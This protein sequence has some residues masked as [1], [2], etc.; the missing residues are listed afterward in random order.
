ML[1]LDLPQRPPGAELRTTAEACALDSQDGVSLCLA[2]GDSPV[3]QPTGLYVRLGKRCFDVAF[4]TTFVVCAATWLFPLIA[5]A[6]RLDSKGP[7]FFRQNRVGFGGRVFSCLKFRTMNHDPEAAFTQAAPNDP[8]VTRVGQVLRRHNL[9]EL[10]QFINVLL[11]EMSVVGPRP[12]VPELDHLYGEQIRDYGAR[13]LVKPGV[14]GLAQIS[15]RRGET[16]RL[17]DMAHRVR[18]DLFYVRRCSFLID[19]RTIIT[20][21]HHSLVGDEKAY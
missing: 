15:G 18:L 21:V 13:N 16:R 3:M 9:D 5:V 10:P 14:T 8:R 20:T 12:H 19:L 17:R 4:S 2:E 1:N 7:V 6:I 11:G